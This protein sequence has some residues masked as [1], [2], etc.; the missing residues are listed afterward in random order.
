M[1]EAFGTCHP[2]REMEWNLPSLGSSGVLNGVFKWGR[3]NPEDLRN[4]L[5]TEGKGEVD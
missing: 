5:R 4:L 1:H 2:E 3:L